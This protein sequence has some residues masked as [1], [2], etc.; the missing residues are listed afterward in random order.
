MNVRSA[1]LKSACLA[2]GLVLASLAA[3]SA[4]EP[5]AEEMMIRA[6][7]ARAGWSDFPGFAANVTVRDNGKVTDGRVTVS[8]D[9]RVEL[10]FPEGFETRG[11]QQ[12]LDS[13]VAHRQAEA[14]NQ[15]DV[16]FA[17]DDKGHPLGRLIKLNEDVMGSHYRIKDDV[18]TEV[19]R[20]MEKV[21]F[22]ISVID[23]ARNADGKYLPRNYTLSTW[24]SATGKLKSTQVVHSDWKAVG[25]YDLPHTILTI[26]SA[27]EGQRT[28]QEIEFRDLRLLPAKGTT[29]AK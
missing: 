9:S 12:K 2:G 18:I 11:L 14:A 8:A 16:V 23:V 20:S 27:D 3:A 4:A 26:S 7:Q 10:Q 24:D 17:D 5:T 21:R 1:G 25:G 13:L 6:H 28:V 19:H 29:A 22:T 15:Y